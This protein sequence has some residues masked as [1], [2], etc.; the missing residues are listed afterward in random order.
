MSMENGSEGSTQN[1]EGQQVNIE[2]MQAQLAELTAKLDQ[3]SKSKERILAESKKYKEGY[4]AYK[5][6]KDAIA[7]E[8]AKADEE[9]LREKGQ[10]DIL[11]KQREERLKEL[12]SQLTE[13]SGKLEAKDEAIVNFRKAAAFERELGGKLKKDS[14][15]SHVDFG[16]IAVNP[17]TNQIDSHSLSKVAEEFR[18]NFKELIDY[19]NN[20]NLPN[21]S[22]SG[23]S[24]SKLTLDQWKALPLADRKKRMKD[25]VKK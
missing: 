19:G 16:N 4:Q 9:K 8:K 2:E 6:E 7:A 5:A 10:F 18:N 25:V 3:E 24:G 20:A 23:T 12:E 21:S 1:V 13:V 22:A 17:D 15:W 14:Y 11:L